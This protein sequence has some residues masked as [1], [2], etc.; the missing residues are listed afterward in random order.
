MA[1]LLL[2]S[3]L[4][5]AAQAP[6]PRAASAGERKAPEVRAI[7]E[8]E[9]QHQLQ[10]KFFYLRGGYFDNDLRFDVD[11]RLIG[12]SPRVSYTLSLLQIEKVHLTRHRLELQGIRYGVHFLGA[13]P[14]EDPLAASDKVR[15][16]PKKKIEK[17]SIER[18]EVV[19][20][21]K[22]KHSKED[23][24]SLVSAS[25]AQAQ[26]P[27]QTAE[28][29]GQLSEYGG[30]VT[31]QA[32]A[33]QLLREAI[34]RVLAKGMDQQL[35]ATLPDFWQRYYEDEGARKAFKPSDPAV[36]PQNAVDQKARLLTNFAAPSSDLA[37]AAGVAGVAQYQ[38]VVGRDGKPEEIAIDRPIGFGL[39]ENAV[40][41]IRK[42]SFQPAMKDGKPVPVLLDLM[43]EFRIFSKRTTPDADADS[44]KV[45]EPQA[46]SLP[47]PYTA[48]QPITKQQ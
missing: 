33:N 2:A 29:A 35:I 27:Q 4:A 34:D 12:N 36:F 21:K 39:D 1:A 17:I 44:A 8:D 48:N 30:I 25:L 43:V 37:Q 9:L 5:W 11:G 40:E 13:G 26:I 22:L 15:I 7:R 14:T 46:P 3:G 28:P 23:A 6:A 24:G 18:A 16:T 41:S 32:R 42:A 45:G 47:G 19:K 38:V 10:G 31:T 20:V